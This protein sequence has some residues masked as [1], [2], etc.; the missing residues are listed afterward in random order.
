[1]IFHDY[2]MVYFQSEDDI[3]SLVAGQES[4]YSAPV[5]I[6]KW[7]KTAAKDSSYSFMFLCLL[8]MDLL[9]LQVFT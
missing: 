4:M 7:K 9:P 3:S 6:S 1:M 8:S 2:V 5:K